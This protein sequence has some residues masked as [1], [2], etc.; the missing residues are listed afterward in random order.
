MKASK[1][2]LLILILGFGGTVE[3]AWRVR[4]HVGGFGRGFWW[5]KY[6]GTSF[7]YESAPE[8]RTVAPGTSL[9][10]ECASHKSARPCCARMRS[11]S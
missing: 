8:V 5:D 11:S 6:G 3:T 2:G 9:A 4:Q 1:I 7:R 10:I